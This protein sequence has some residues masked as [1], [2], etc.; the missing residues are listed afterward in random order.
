MLMEIL[1]HQKAMLHCLQVIHH[2]SGPNEDFS[3]TMLFLKEAH[4]VL[5][6]NGALVISS[7]SRDQLNGTI[8][9]YSGI[10]PNAAE[11]LILR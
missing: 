6:P 9:Y 7:S 1:G 2:L 5:V 3:H 4:R 10:I 8:W 11:R